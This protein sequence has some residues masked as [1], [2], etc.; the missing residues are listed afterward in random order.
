MGPHAPSPVAVTHPQREAQSLSFKDKLPEASKGLVQTQGPL[1]LKAELC[2]TALRAEMETRCWW[3]VV[4]M[5]SGRFSAAQMP[6]WLHS[7]L[8]E[9]PGLAGKPQWPSQGVH[10]NQ[11]SGHWK[12][13]FSSLGCDQVTVSSHQIP[14]QP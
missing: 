3:S 4:G 13:V 1:S 7:A 5:E 8:P 9:L 6:S 10:S 11:L 12:P 2:P 14:K